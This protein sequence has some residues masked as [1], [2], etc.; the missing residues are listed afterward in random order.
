MLDIFRHVTKYTAVRD[1]I[2]ITKAL[3]DPT[4]LRVLCALRSRELCVC[5]V[6]ELLQLAPSTVSKHLS[7]L[8]QAGLV[9]SRKDERWVYYRWPDG[10]APVRVR[11]AL[12]WVSKA[13]RRNPQVEADRQQLKA[14]LKLNPSDL[15]KRQCRN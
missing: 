9:T 1:F 12:D 5:Q 10:D 4:R 14:I 2:G 7:L 8:Q 3:S 15:C 6:T 13:L 11:E